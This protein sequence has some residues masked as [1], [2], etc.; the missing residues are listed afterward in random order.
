MEFHISENN[1][2]GS[3][4]GIATLTDSSEELLNRLENKE[5]YSSFMEK[6]AEHRKREWLSVRVLLKEMLCEEKEIHYTGFGKPY[7]ADHSYHISISHTKGF[8]AVILNKNKQVAIDIEQIAPRVERI[9]NRFMN[10]TEE[11]NLSKKNPLLHLLLHW[12][13]KETLY[14]WLNEPH[15]N[16]Q[17]QLHIHFFEPEQ[18][19]WAEF[20]AHETQTAEQ[21]HFTIRYKITGNYVLT[22]IE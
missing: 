5:L 11:K 10:E 16:F 15:I 13:A 8:A 14:K 1:S 12:S 17:T 7:L 6:P 21:Q 20:T 9:R 2:T 18:N 22:A 4:I 19:N 3:I